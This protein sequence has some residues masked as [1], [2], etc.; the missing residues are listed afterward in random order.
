MFGFDR[1]RTISTQSATA[2]ASAAVAF[3]QEDD[4]T[5]VTIERVANRE[6]SFAEARAPMSA[7]A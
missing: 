3:G 6:T 2:I 5:V 1:G 4:I 7:P